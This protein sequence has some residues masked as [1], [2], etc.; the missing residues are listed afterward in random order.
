MQ[1]RPL[2]KRAKSSP[3]INIS[4]PFGQLW[5][6]FDLIAIDFSMSKRFQ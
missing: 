1:L 2:P 3:N 4:Y 6:Y 5:Q